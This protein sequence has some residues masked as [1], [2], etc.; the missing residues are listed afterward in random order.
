MVREEPTNTRTA[1]ID[2][3][4]STMFTLLL[5]LNVMCGQQWIQFEFQNIPSRAFAIDGKIYTTIFL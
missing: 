4:H 5:E 3:N 2:T 1:G